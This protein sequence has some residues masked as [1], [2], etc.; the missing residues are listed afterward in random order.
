MTNL[1]YYKM[2]CAKCGH[3][4]RIGNTTSFLKLFFV[5]YRCRACGHFH[6]EYGENQWKISF[7]RHERTVTFSLT[8]PSTWF[9][10]YKWVEKE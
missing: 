7:G 10:K 6:D 9:P 1:Y 3:V 8:K 2:S 4:V 5:G